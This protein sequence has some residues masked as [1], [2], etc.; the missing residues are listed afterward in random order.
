MVHALEQAHRL[1]RP[2]GWLINIQPLPVARRIEVRSPEIKVEISYSVD[3]EDR[4]DEQLA[5]NALNQV[6]RRGLYVVEDEKDIPLNVHGD[7][8]TEWQESPSEW[9][10]STGLQTNTF[11]RAESAFRKA[12]PGAEIVIRYPAR[13]TKL[14]V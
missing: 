14:R 8:L 2:H 13:A 4:H 6:I 1:L 12:G 5:V 7:S 3:T 9:W 11:R 10:G